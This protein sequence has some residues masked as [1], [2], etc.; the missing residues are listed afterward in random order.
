MRAIEACCRRC[1][2][3]LGCAAE[4]CIECRG[5]RLAFDRAWAPF[6]YA[7]S[8]R[9]MILALKG[10]DLTAGVSY[11][12]AAITRRAPP[13]LLAGVLVPV[14]AHGARLWQHGHNQAHQLATALG[15][16]TGLA[17]RDVLARRPGG[18][19][20]VGL[21]RHARR[22]NARAWI[23]ARSGHPAGTQAVLVDDVYTTGSTLDACAVELLAAGAERVSA[24]CF[25][26]TVRG[27]TALAPRR[28]AA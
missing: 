14:P 8:A 20:Q 4:A 10:R 9:E 25:A 28:G 3:P 12:A 13:G 6:A 15:R 26:R 1:G 16:L 22:D 7:G 23:R 18:V 2:A 5:Q 27:H 17:V 11:M 24:V 19:R 21:E